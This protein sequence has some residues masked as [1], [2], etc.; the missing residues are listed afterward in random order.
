M[1]QEIEVS[2]AQQITTAQASD[3]LKKLSQSDPVQGDKTPDDDRLPYQHPNVLLMLEHPGGGYG[4]CFSH[5]RYLSQTRLSVITKVFMH[6]GS[7]VRAYLPDRM[8]MPEEQDGT[9]LKCNYISNSMHEVQ[10][11][12]KHKINLKL[13]MDLPAHFIVDSDAEVDPKQIGGRVLLYSDDQ[14]DVKLVYHFTRQT[15]VQFSEAASLGGVLDLIR[16]EPFDLVLCG[17]MVQGVQALRVR[18][19]LQDA[20]FG[21]TFTVIEPP[22]LGVSAYADEPGILSLLKPLTEAGVVNLFGSVLGVCIGGEGDYLY[23]SLPKD[24]SNIELIDWYIDHVKC[25]VHELHKAAMAEAV[26]EA[27]RYIA[28]LRDTGTS[29][30]FAPISESAAGLLKSINASGSVAECQAEVQQ[31]INLTRQMRPHPHA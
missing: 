27:R 31:C 17:D 3:V 18:S 11:L 14:A 19:A 23:S 30:G 6:V 12:L 5:T 21:A 26:D 15:R 1:N 9:V 29:Y 16:S 13:F 4:R 10:I 25:L 22:S 20:G 7:K 2:A 24:D 28:T 8:G